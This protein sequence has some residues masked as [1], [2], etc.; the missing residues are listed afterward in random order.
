ML[1]KWRDVDGFPGYRVSNLG[2]VKGPRKNSLKLVDGG[3][4]YLKVT[5]SNNGKHMDKRVN[6]L[7]AQAFLPNPENLPVVM[8]RDNDRSNNR[9][10]NLAWGT[11]SENNQWMH[12]CGRHPTNISDEDREKAYKIRRSPVKSINLDTLE[13]RFFDSQHDAARSLGVS[14]QHIWGVL[15]GHRRSTGGYRFE[16]MAKGGHDDARK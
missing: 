5:L 8:H 6:R 10:D 4:G 9:V 2:R 3:Q 14:Q 15:N 16:Y 11:Y 12:T 13:E 7:V 1:E